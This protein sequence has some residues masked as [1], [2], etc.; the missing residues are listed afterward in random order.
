MLANL[1][2]EVHFKNVFTDVEVFTAFAKD[3]LGIDLQI[4]K[5]ETEKILPSKVSAIKFRMDLF[6]EDSER[7]TIV[8]IQK[9]DYDY[10]YDRFAHYFLAN[11]IDMQRSSK[12]YNFDKEVFVIVVV[13]AAYRISEL[14]GQPVKDDVLVTKINPRNLKDEERE[15]TK[16]K[17]VILNTTYV[18]ENTPTAIKDWMDLI[19]ESM[20]NREKPNINLNKAGI[21][22][23]AKLAELNELSP[24]QLAEAKIM[25]MRKATIA[26]VEDTT[27]KETEEKLRKETEEKINYARKETEEKLRKETTEKVKNARIETEQKVKKETEQRVKKESIIKALDQKK[28]TKEEIAEL[29]EVSLEQIIEIKKGL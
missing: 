28:L 22:K 7:R 14:N 9:V 21:A 4:K 19:T 16:H 11:L 6:A 18:D 23:A 15:M 25:E 12:Y 17:M 29:F 13:T 8:E 24:E 5:V 1:D 10:S 3:I 27:R 2:N 20:N 26:L